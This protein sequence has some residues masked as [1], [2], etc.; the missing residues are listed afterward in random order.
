MIPPI[1]WSAQ[2]KVGPTASLTGRWFVAKISSKLTKWSY[3][4][5]LLV[6]ELTIRCSFD[7]SGPLRACR[8]GSCGNKHPFHFTCILLWLY[9]M[10]HCRKKDINLNDF[11]LRNRKAES[12]P[13]QRSL[14]A[15]EKTRISSYAVLHKQAIGVSHM[16]PTSGMCRT[17]APPIDNLICLEWMPSPPMIYF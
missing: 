13:F 17:I 2:R 6:R 10:N 5:I 3:P 11:S 1:Q 8:G 7:E 15:E 16:L 14:Y 9:F 12:S 4:S